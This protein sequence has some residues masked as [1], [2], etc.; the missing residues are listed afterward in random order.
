MAM[1]LVLMRESGA[2]IAPVLEVAR[3]AAAVLVPSVASDSP[4][5]LGAGNPIDFAFPWFRVL[6][7]WPEFN[8]GLT[9]AAA[10]PAVPC[11]ASFAFIARNR[12]RDR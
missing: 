11:C 9:C 6:P 1:V 2:P 12:A 8:F 3:V 5:L 4:M 10:V 7:T